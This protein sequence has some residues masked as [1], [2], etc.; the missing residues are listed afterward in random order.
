M[1]QILT[2][3]FMREVD[4]RRRVFQ[5]LLLAFEMIWVHLLVEQ[6][7]SAADFCALSVLGLIET[8]DHIDD[9]LNNSKTSV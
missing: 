2:Y 5:R 7:I 8:S 6:Y 1:T 9:K 3:A 4:R